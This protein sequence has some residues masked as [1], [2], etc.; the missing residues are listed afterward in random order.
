MGRQA[1]AAKSEY[2]Y[3][4]WR[5]K[6][7][8]LW[9]VTILLLCLAIVMV[10]GATRITGSGLSITEWQPV[11]GVVPPLSA[12]AWQAEFEKYKQI[13]QYRVVNPDLNL[14]GFKGI[15]WWEWS[16]RFL[17]RIIGL[18]ASIPLLVV[19]L[20]AVGYVFCRRKSCEAPRSNPFLPYFIIVPCLVAVQGV[21]GWWMVYSGL[22]HSPLT[23]VSQYRLATHLI[24]ACLIIGLVTYLVSGLR[25]FSD[26]P[27]P[28]CVQFT[29]VLVVFAVFIQIYLGGLVAGLHAGLQYN[30]WPLMDGKIVPSGLFTLVPIWKNFFENVLTV[31]FMHRL[32][33]DAVLFFAVVHFLQLYSKYGFS[34]GHSKRALGLLVMVLLQLCFGVVTLLL[35]VP[36][37]WGLL[38]QFFA[39]LLFVA[40]IVHLRWL[41]Q[42]KVMERFE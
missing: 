8:R 35:K 30:T 39:L 34:A 27:A 10:G 18:I 4:A 41:M 14:A 42:H 29:G 32:G 15:Y 20:K 31:Q 23:S 11:H 38:H 37:F 40:S 9:L 19:V 1:L 13:A 6:A 7:L 16:H 25:R 3:P 21:I 33:G 22:A 36:I 2:A 5:I 28:K 24:A 17:A 12:A 26:C